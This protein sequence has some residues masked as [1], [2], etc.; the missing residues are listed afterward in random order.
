MSM[1]SGTT[2]K[3]HFGVLHVY[4]VYYMYVFTLVVHLDARIKGLLLS[5]N[6]VKPIS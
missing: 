1:I 6:Y 5:A 3:E 2:L 4:V